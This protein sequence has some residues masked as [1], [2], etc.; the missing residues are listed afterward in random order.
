[1]KSPLD[2]FG[3]LITSEY[4][5]QADRTDAQEIINWVFSIMGAI[6]V[7]MIVYASIQFVLSQGNSDKV[8]TARKTIIYAAAGLVV[9]SIAWGLVSLVADRLG[10]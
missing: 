6:A 10:S 1:M 5:P 3:A 4:L 8:A 2:Y 7:L 9:M